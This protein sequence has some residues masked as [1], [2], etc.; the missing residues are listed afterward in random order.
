M[1][2]TIEIV[3]EKLST[4]RLWIERAIVALY[5]R[6]TEDEKEG[7]FT[8]EDNGVGFNAFDSPFLSN[9]AEWLIA[10]KNNGHLTNNQLDVAKKKMP[11]YAKQI[12]SLIPK[13]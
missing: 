9:L 10:G 7:R 4:N 2:Y 8:A 5:N 11:K 6:Q 13:Q 12:L 1:E 3:K